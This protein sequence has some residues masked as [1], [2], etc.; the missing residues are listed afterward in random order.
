[1]S[2]ISKD[3]TA[4]DD[5]P[6]AIGD[7]KTLRAWPAEPPDW[8][9]P[10]DAA[11]CRRCRDTGVVVRSFATAAEYCR[12]YGL[13]EEDM[14]RRERSWFARV[15]ASGIPATFAAPCAC[16]SRRERERR[17]EQAVGGLPRALAE[18]RLEEVHRH[19][20]YKAAALARARAFVR[21]LAAG[22]GGVLVF[23]GETGTGKTYV[24]VA[25]L[26]AAV[27]AGLRGAFVTSAEFCD[28][29]RERCYS[30]A[31]VRAYIRELRGHD[32]VV[33]DDFGSERV[34]PAEG[35]VLDHYA[36]FLK[37]FEAGGGLMITTNLDLQRALTA[38]FGDE[39]DRIARRLGE[40]QFGPTLRFGAGA[41]GER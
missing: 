28:D 12:R 26:R 18:A 13:A 33:L 34:G 4:G 11:A 3:K 39:G 1:M 21:R 31:D 2:G 5:A 29:L 19:V 35:A 17:F 8:L 27:D 40:A 32:L 7:T 14:T 38:R 37:S 36:R 30:V 23:A 10:D 15:E 22:E 6:A 25:S 41:Q 24:A 20:A 16:A 9:V